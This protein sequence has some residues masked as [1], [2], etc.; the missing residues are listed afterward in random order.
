VPQ[1]PPQTQV[2]IAPPLTAPTTRPLASPANFASVRDGRAALRLRC[3][4]TTTCNGTLN[5]LARTATIAKAKPKKPASY[6]TA[7]YKI[8]A[9]KTATIKVKLSKTGRAALRKKKKLPILVTGGS[10][11]AAWTLKLT[12]KR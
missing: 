2:P 1:L 8:A 12:L 3:L 10:G 6:G 4:L 5:L 11:T 9:G 7:K